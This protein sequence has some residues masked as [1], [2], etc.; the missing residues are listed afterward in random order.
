MRVQ[1]ENF[2]LTLSK[3]TL[4]NEE[5]LNKARNI[6]FDSQKDIRRILNHKPISIE[7]K[8]LEG[9]DTLTVV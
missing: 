6:L 3:L 7:V 5:K 2:H 1:P 8:G 4:E 9:F